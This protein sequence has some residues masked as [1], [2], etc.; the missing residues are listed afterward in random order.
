VVE[1]EA[2]SLE[3]AAG[4]VGIAAQVTQPYA[5]RLDGWLGQG[6]AANGSSEATP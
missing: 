5:Q 1:P 3:L 2:G 4:E 6:G